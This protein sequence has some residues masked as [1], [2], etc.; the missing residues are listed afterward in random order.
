[1]NHYV[2]HSNPLVRIALAICL[3]I[4]LAYSYPQSTVLWKF[5]FIISL[6]LILIAQFGSLITYRYRFATGILIFLSYLLLSL[7]I[8][9]QFKAH[10]HYSPIS[11]IG[12]SNFIV[13][14]QQKLV[15][16]ENSFQSL[17]KI[18]D[19]TNSQLSN[20][21]LLLYFPK[22]ELFSTLTVGDSLLTNQYVNEIE[23]AKNP[24]QFNYK[25]FLARQSIYYQ[26]YISDKNP[27]VFLPAE[28][29]KISF[30]ES[31]REYS[32]HYFRQNLKRDNSALATA[33]FLG[34]KSNLDSEVS[35]DFQDSGTMHVLAVSGLHIGILFA[36]VLLFFRAVKT[37]LPNS[38]PIQ[39]VVLLLAIWIFVVLAGAK[40]SST[41][42]GVMFSILAIGL[43][44]SAKSFP[45]NSL[46]FA[47]IILLVHNPD[48]LFDVGFQLSFSA[49][50]GIVILVPWFQKIV[51][52]STN[53]FLSYFQ[54]IT[55]VSIAAQLATLPFVLFYFQQ[56][57]VFGLVANLFVIPLA[58]LL[59]GSGFVTLLLSSIPILNTV[60]SF[61]LE[62]QL[63]LLQEFN[64]LVSELPFATISNIHLSSFEL[65]ILFASIS[66][67][68]GFVISKHKSWIWFITAF[69]FLFFGSQAMRKLQ[70]E[71]STE[72]SFY[73]I[74]KQTAFEF[75]KG[76][77]A[78]LFSTDTITDQQYSYFIEANHK[79]NSIKKVHYFLID[80]D[81]VTPDF[82]LKNKHFSS[83]EFQLSVI[84]KQDSICKSAPYL[85][86]I[87]PSYEQFEA[88]HS[89]SK[90]RQVLI[91]TTYP[92]K[93]EQN[94]SQ[95]IHFLQSGFSS[96]SQMNTLK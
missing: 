1:M 71:S 46:A 6:I 8:A 68:Y 27:I 34:D 69:L 31:I 11:S 95:G 96:S 82:Y 7:S 24:H 90:Q 51:P 76:R 4:F 26:S 73:S 43:L 93:L 86:F 84:S 65:F 72:L 41:R 9:G 59:V 30:I 81:S 17:G 15:E 74:P 22:N 83:P 39:T 21:N 13:E 64:Q 42:A 53:K 2:V 3:G 49:V 45:I 87:E 47:A 62:L 20:Q 40:A 19:H 50:L 52:L 60:T 35:D 80:Q 12:K 36:I 89:L 66:S 16:K 37:W 67:I 94:A 18:V 54:N 28:V 48:Y 75:R 33:L 56:Y 14:I 5:T 70:L 38:K 55:Y 44:F 78:N 58:F 57:A 25:D 23:T 85:V 91:S 29:N 92:S 61:L 63:E 79:A 77:V 88:I 10:K 32:E